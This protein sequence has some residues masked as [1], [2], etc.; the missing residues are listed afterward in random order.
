MSD[1]SVAETYPKSLI[2]NGGAPVGLLPLNQLLGAGNARNLTMLEV[3]ADF[4]RRAIR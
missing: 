2:A 3:E 4:L 1:Q